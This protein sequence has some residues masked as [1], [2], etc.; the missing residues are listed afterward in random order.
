MSAPS[1]RPVNRMRPGVSDIRHM[2]V[3]HEDRAEVRVG[4]L[5]EHLRRPD[6]LVRDE[7]AARRSTGAIG[8]ARLGEGVDDLVPV[9]CGD[10]S[11]DVLVEQVGVR[12]PAAAR[13]GEPRLVD[14][15]GVADEAHDPLGDA[16]ARWWRPRPTSPSLVR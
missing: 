15:L 14:D 2:H 5:D 16:S 8:G 3:V 10:P 4:Y 9:R 6:V 7:V 13:T 1:A 11:A 12:G